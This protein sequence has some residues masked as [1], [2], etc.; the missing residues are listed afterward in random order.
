MLILCKL[1]RL[2]MKKTATLFLVTL[3][4]SLGA[5]STQGEKV[6]PYSFNS[7]KIEYKISGDINGNMTAFVKGDHSVNKVNAT[8]AADGTPVSTL[9]IDLGET[10]Y[11]IDQTKKEG[12]SSTNYIYE[13][14][15]GLSKNEKL[16]R[17]TAYA[18]NTY[19]SDVKAEKTGQKEYAGQKCDLYQIDG[20][21]ICLW[22]GIPLYSNVTLGAD[23]RTIEATGIQ[24]EIEV[25]DSEF[26]LPEGISIQDVEAAA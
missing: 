14:L 20:G 22:Q 19:S 5:C 7:A 26:T 6:V 15:K 4:L 12:Y 10:I 11:F 1:N 16:E 18:T 24:T 3:L 21:E 8:N 25:A 2:N 23:A 17:L 13:D 9:T